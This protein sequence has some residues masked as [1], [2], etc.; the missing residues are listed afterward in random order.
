MKFPGN[1]NYYIKPKQN[2][3]LGNDLID[4]FDLS[5]MP[6]TMGEI[7]EY[8]KMLSK[9]STVLKVKDEG[10][11][12]KIL[13]ED[14]RVVSEIYKSSA[15]SLKYCS[16]YQKV[17]KKFKINSV[18][19]LGTSLGISTLSFALA[20]DGVRVTTIEACPQT[21]RYTRSNFN[22]LGLNNVEFIN[23]TFDSV[24]DN[25]I[26]KGRSFDMIFLDGNHQYRSTLNYYHYINENLSAGQCI[27]LF[28]DIN[29]T[30]EMYRAW[31]EISAMNRKYLRINTGRQGIV[32]RAFDEFLDKE[33]PINF[34]KVKKNVTIYNYF[35][36]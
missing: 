28:D 32:F 16:L 4:L 5:Y 36:T 14:K 18:L 25:E 1:I 23:N 24:F 19:E 3:K 7:Y 21:L 8:S 9:D 26:L 27:Y 35:S 11:G 15:S 20:R 10:A 30:I 13:R 2:K 17:I 6:A 22:N 33:F 31:K 34:V 29:W 12:S